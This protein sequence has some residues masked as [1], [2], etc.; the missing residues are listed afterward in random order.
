MFLWGRLPPRPWVAVVGTRRA[1]DAALDF[2]RLLCR[3]LCG[4]GVTVSS[5]GAQGIDAAAH[6]GALEAGGSTVVIAPSSYERP[7]P[8]AHAELF[9]RIIDAGGAV[10][11]E[12]ERGV[13]ARRHVFFARNAILAASCSALVLVEAPFRSGARNATLWAR[14]LGRPVFVVPHPPWHTAGRGCITELVLGGRPLASYRDVTS[15]LTDAGH[16]LVPGGAQ[17]TVLQGELWPVGEDP[18]RPAAEASAQ[19]ARSGDDEQADECGLDA[20]DSL[21]QLLPNEAFASLDSLC[22]R[23]GLATAVVQQRLTRWVLAGCVEVGALGY[24][25]TR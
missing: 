8:A 18:G 25:R 10:L 7:Y 21:R 17:P 16:V 5:G 22:E 3:Q 24:R 14:R 11:S 12:H 23:S 13:A 6:E 9:Q 15:A 2:T 1:S 20:S 19:Q 4:A